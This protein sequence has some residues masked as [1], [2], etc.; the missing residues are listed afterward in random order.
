MTL[1]VG[2]DA[3]GSGV[4]GSS[5][6]DREIDA[7]ME[8]AFSVEGIDTLTEGAGDAAFDG[9]ERGS[10]GGAS[11]IRERGEMQGCILEAC[12]SGSGEGRA[13]ERVE[14]VERCLVLLGLH[15]VIGGEQAGVGL[16][17]VDGRDFAGDGAQRCDL[18]IL[19]F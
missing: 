4:D 5:V 7:A 9:P 8:C 1:G 11:P 6:G 18:D 16:E 12:G 15:V 10:I 17:S 2:D 14:G 3:V 19:L 13:T